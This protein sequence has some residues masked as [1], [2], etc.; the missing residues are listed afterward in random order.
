MS[1][2]LA[3][4][5]LAT[6]VTSNSDPAHYAIAE[7]KRIDAVV[8]AARS[9]TAPQQRVSGAMQ[10]ESSYSKLADLVRFRLKDPKRA[11]ALYRKAAETHRVAFPA[12]AGSF[13]SIDI[14]DI[15]QFDLKDK[16]LAA[17]EYE[18]FLQSLAGAPARAEFAWMR[19]WLTHELAYLRNG[20]RFN[21]AVSV[22]EA[23]A[24]RAFLY[25]FGTG[26]TN[27]GEP[28][29]LASPAS[30][31]TFARTFAAAAQLTDEK[32]LSEWLTRNDPAGY[33]RA[34]YLSLAGYVTQLAPPKAPGMMLFPGVPLPLDGKLA[35]AKMGRAFVRK[36]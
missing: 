30:H 33:W 14:G 15:Y 35:I 4:L 7:E 17:A 20:T 24:F 6:A 34:S 27:R 31:L 1:L 32:K 28:A 18:K 5:L 9:A 25:F 21:G 36:K 2:V 26:E 8:A 29:T 19:A 16:K 23:D 10:A 12:G 13:A 22:Q 3:V 11:I